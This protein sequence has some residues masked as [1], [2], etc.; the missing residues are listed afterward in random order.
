MAERRMFAKNIIESDAFYDLSME[1][2]VLYLHL[3]MNADDDGIVDNARA[4]TRSCGLK[5]NVL[6]RLIELRFLMRLENGLILIKHWKI[7]NYVQKDRYKP[8]A[9][10]EEFSAVELKD[11]GS[12]TEKNKVYETP[13]RAVEM[14]DTEED[15]ALD[16]QESDTLDTQYAD[17]QVRLG[18]D[19]LGKVRLGKDRGMGEGPD[20]RFQRPTI[21]DVK[22]YCIERG[23]NV[24]PQRWYD[25]Y[26][27]NG[28]K[29]GKNSMKDWKAAVRTWERNNPQPK[30]PQSSFMDMA[31]EIVKEYGL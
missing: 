30:Q 1:E 14:V 8:T 10:A 6:D 22:A 5:T 2:Q 13:D 28:W 31:D 29:V 23:N 7:N 16:T 17:T 19:R 9:Y 24:D 21:Q 11:N 25:Y 26:S 15:N 18:K 27:A 12:Y 4:V 20:K 3:G